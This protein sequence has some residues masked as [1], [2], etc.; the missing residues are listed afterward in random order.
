VTTF[1][2]DQL[3]TLENL[4]TKYDAVTAMITNIGNT[5]YADFDITLAVNSSVI[6]NMEQICT[7]FNLV[8]SQSAFL[9]L[10]QYLV[11]QGT[12]LQHSLAAQ[13]A[14]YGFSAT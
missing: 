6:Y 7:T 14:S 4:T 9:M 5:T 2:R 10:Q 8:N 1:T 12:I 13:I 3:N 11:A